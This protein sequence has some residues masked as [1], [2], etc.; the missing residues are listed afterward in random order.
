[1]R[2]NDVNEIEVPGLAPPYEDEGEREGTQTPVQRPMRPSSVLVLSQGGWGDGGKK[3]RPMSMPMRP[4][5]TFMPS[6][7]YGYEEPTGDE[8][9]PTHDGEESTHDTKRGIPSQATEETTP[10]TT[11]ETTLDNMSQQ[12]DLVDGREDES[13]EPDASMSAFFNYCIGSLSKYK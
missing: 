1:M 11:Q 5:G 12:R 10:Q 7:Y 13:P 6:T 2:D 8:E 4:A 9:E 3:A